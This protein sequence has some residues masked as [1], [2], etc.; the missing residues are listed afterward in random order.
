MRKKILV[1]NP[2]SLF[3][4]IMASQD[5]VYN[6]IK[7][8]SLDHDVDVLTFYKTEQEKND[9]ENMLKNYCK[10]LSQVR[11]INGYSK[12]A[13]KL[14]ALKN[15]LKLFLFNYPINYSVFS[16][17]YYCEN[18]LRI[19]DKYDYDI[20][21]VEYWYLGYVLKKINSGCIKVIDTHDV[22][23]DKKEQEIKKLH[24]GKL[25]GRKAKEI[26]KYQ[27]LELACLQNSDLL[28]SITQQDYEKFNQL[29]PMKKNIIVST[30][31]DVEHYLQYKS[32]KIDNSILFYGSMGAPANIDAFFRFWN[33]VLPFVKEKIN[34]VKVYVVGS[35]PPKQIKE[36]DNA[37]DVIVT[38]FVEDVREYLSK[39]AVSVIP[40][41]V[42]AGFRSRIVEVMAMG[43]PVVGTSNALG[44]FEMEHGVHGFI[45]N[46]DKKIAEYLIKLLSDDE[47]RNQ[48]SKNCKKFVCE[49][50]SIEATYGNLSNYYSKLSLAS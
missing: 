18:I 34:D 4:K 16:E 49:K 46:D 7:R 19:I 33:K 40:L 15:I 17:K 10:N 27:A 43:I 25:T 24:E 44:S 48:L 9:S 3:P 32:N 1:I 39:S 21:Q 23:F 38:R 35:N 50:Y 6:L 31:Q 41:N 26:E 12:I 47:F 37:K 29:L 14:F 20:V 30:G 45:E 28:I 11:V 22:L 13:R 42:A 36:L 2:I 5:R 8:L